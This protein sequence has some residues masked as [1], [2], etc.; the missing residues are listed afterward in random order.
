VA[1]ASLPVESIHVA[2]AVRIAFTSSQ[3]APA[4]SGEQF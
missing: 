1:G 4:S 3:T 2:S